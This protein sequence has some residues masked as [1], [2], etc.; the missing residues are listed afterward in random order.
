MRFKVVLIASA[1]G[2]AGGMTDKKE[3]VGQLANL[4]MQLTDQG[5][6]RGKDI[7]TK[8]LNNV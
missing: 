1:G 8:L 2:R 5:S 3:I 6:D 7:S 4:L